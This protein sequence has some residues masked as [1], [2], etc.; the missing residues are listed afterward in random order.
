M[1]NKSIQRRTRLS[2]ALTSLRRTN[3]KFSTVN[4]QD[5]SETS[6]NYGSVNSEWMELWMNQWYLSDVEDHASKIILRYRRR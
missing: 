2:S 6:S 3:T 5:V 1:L 4:A